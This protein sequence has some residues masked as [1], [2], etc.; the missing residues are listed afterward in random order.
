MNLRN[1][2]L[3]V[4]DGNPKHLLGCYGNEL[5]DTPRIDAFAASGVRFERAFCTHSVC[6]PTR[7]SLYTGRY[8]HI[9][10]V[11]ANGV[12][13]PESEV[14]MPEVLS[15]AGHATCAS[16]KIH[17]EP[18]EQF[19][20]DC[21]PAPET[22]YY[23]FGE[24]HLSENRLGEEYL[25][26]IDSE[27]PELSERARERSGMPAEAHELAW[28]TD[29]AI[30]F[31]GRQARSETPFFCHC[32]YHELSPPCHAP[33]GWTGQ[34]DPAEVPVPEL[35]A[36]D[37]AKK[38][39]WYRECY[40]GYLAN[41][42][43]PDEPTLRRSIASCYDQM[44]FIDHQF[45]R[46]LDALEQSG[47]AEETLVILIADHGLS[48]ND[49]FQWRHGPF[50]FDEVTNVPMIARLPGGATGAVCDDL[51]EGVDIM[52]T[53]LDL[54]E[55]PQP[56]GVQGQSIAPILRGDRGA[57][58]RDSVLLQEREAPDLAARGLSPDR[59]TQWAVRTADWKLIHYPGEDFGELYDLRNDPGEFD[60]RWSDPACAGQR[61]EL[62]RL[63]LDRIAESRDP[64][65]ERHHSW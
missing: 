23:G 35:R 18:Q 15:E 40:E 45:G 5:A 14:T 39:E 46:L 49:H 51:I 22:P 16:G 57:R 24:V 42:R 61:Q 6:M 38:P 48:L 7:A 65:P 52:P 62:E 25:A 37:L 12:R 4:T 3:F 55:A 8:P 54:L 20:G 64:L 29:R 60:N 58:G 1:A 34:Y 50:L 27:Y 53:I 44:R 33:E 31:I 43:Q 47:V 2:V 11:W 13:L 21:L 59:V 9:H 56:A 41:G 30:D 32:S 10:G 26:F 19:S 63:L 28:I 36:D 17:F